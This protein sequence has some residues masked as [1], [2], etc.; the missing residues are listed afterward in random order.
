MEFDTG[1]SGPRP[2]VGIGEALFDCFA[3]RTILGG[4]PLNAVLVAHALG[5]SLGLRGQMV[6][7]VGSDALGSELISSLQ[8]RGLVTDSVQ[9]DAAHATGTVQV[10]LVDGEPEYDII[11]DVAWDHIEWSDSLAELATQAVGVTFGTLAQR[12]HRS[13]QTIQKFLAEAT[14]ATRLFDVNL[15][16]DDYTP[17]VLRSSCRLATAMKL[18][19]GELEI[20]SEALGIPA[21]LETDRV[22]ADLAETLRQEFELR[23]VILTHGKRGT[24]LITDAGAFTAEVPH[25]PAQP[26]S[27]PVGAGDACGATCLL[28]LVLDWEPQQ[29]VQRANRVGAFV[30]SQQGATPSLNPEQLLA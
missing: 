6:S 24:Q 16:G 22:A 4:A 29:I 21:S 9:V 2:I 19:R 3:D 15:R 28:G 27:D 20:V 1:I 7:R 18:N 13:M 14:N 23:A 11:T 5:E 25:F 17:E 10:T 26:G 12:S 8:S 30:A